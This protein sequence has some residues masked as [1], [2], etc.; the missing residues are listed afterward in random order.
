MKTTK[1]IIEME[2][3]EPEQL[4]LPEPP[5]SELPQLSQLSRQNAEE[6]LIAHGNRE[7]FKRRVDEEIELHR[8]WC[9]LCKRPENAPY[10]FSPAKYRESRVDFGLSTERVQGTYHLCH[11]IR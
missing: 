9:Q 2:H 11:D 7:R 4:E 10:V 3:V 1:R 6:E 8:F 5:C